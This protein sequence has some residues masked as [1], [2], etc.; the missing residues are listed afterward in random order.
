[1]KWLTKLFMPSAKSLAEYAADRIAKSLNEAGADTQE[2]VAKYAAL[3]AKATEVANALAKMVDDGNISKME[4]ATLVKM[5][6][7]LMEKVV[8]VV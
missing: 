3:A 5:L 6:T 1:M 8:A 7:P 4:R 2:K